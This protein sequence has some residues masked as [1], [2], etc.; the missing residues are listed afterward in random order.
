MGVFF[1][2]AANTGLISAR[3]KKSD[4]K[5]ICDANADGGGAQAVTRF[6]YGMFRSNCVYQGELVFQ[7]KATANHLALTQKCC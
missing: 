2:C 6:I 1:V 7:L 4:E 5:R 3:V